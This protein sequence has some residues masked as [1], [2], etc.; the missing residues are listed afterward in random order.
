MLKTIKSFKQHQLHCNFLFNSHK[1]QASEP[2]LPHRT[3]R[4]TL[5]PYVRSKLEE[6][7]KTHWENA[8]FQLVLGQLKEQA[9]KDEEDSIDGVVSI[10]ESDKA[11]EAVAKNVLWQMDLDRKTKSL[12]QL[13]GHIWR[14]GYKNGDIKGQFVLF[15]LCCSLYDDVVPALKLWTQSGRQLYIYS[16]GSVE[17]QKLLFG[18]SQ[19]GDLLELFS[20]YF[21]TEVGPKVEADSYKN[22]VE[23]LHC[24]P[25]DVVFFTDVSKVQQLRVEASARIPYLVESV[26]A[27]TESF[28]SQYVVQYMNFVLVMILLFRPATRGD[29]WYHGTRLGSRTQ[30]PEL[31]V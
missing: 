28:R 31:Q 1:F 26:H 14:D 6:Y 15:G 9:K 20:G 4:D 22:I 8:E 25:E 13:Q 29:Y 5:F 11:I 24:E 17:A 30:D 18:H 3:M 19:D 7:L 23:R 2:V 21:D 16:S 10:P 12:K 27:F